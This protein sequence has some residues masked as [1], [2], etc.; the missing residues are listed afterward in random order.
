MF[1]ALMLRGTNSFSF[2]PFI[3]YDDVALG[4]AFLYCLSVLLCL[5]PP[6]GACRLMR[7]SCVGL[8][9]FHTNAQEHAKILG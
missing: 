5:V 8:V 1:N 7:Q 3:C 4:T 9:A 6:A 2:S